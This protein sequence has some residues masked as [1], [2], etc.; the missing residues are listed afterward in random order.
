[1]LTEVINVVLISVIDIPLTLLLAWILLKERPSFGI[2]IAAFIAMSGILITFFLH[3]EVMPE[4]MKMSM[5]NIGEGPVAQLLTRLPKAG[6]ICIALATFFTV[7]SVEFSRKF[8][9]EV[10]IGIYGVFRMVIGAIIFFII[11]A[12]LLG[13]VHFIDLLNPFLL[14]WMLVYGI[15]VIALGLY[16]WDRALVETSS[17]DLAIANAFSPVAGIFFAYLILGEVPEFGQ[18]IGGSIILIGI[19]IGLFAKLK[20]DREEKI[21][22]KKPRSFSGV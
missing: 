10:P 18:I 14:E 11:A 8:L 13:F 21:G 15:G 1:M 2:S 5:V 9:N 7:F 16:F 19:A 20:K 22:Y 17:G 6:E 4:T 12:S 3:E